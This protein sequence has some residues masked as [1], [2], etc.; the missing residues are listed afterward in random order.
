[1]IHVLVLRP[2]WE[3]T[4]FVRLIDITF[5]PPLEVNDLVLI[6]SETTYGWNTNDKLVP[7]AIRDYRNTITA[8]FNRMRHVK[9][10]QFINPKRF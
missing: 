10:F 6:L 8:T 7:I 3:C 5:W 9:T 2:I 4:K 1:M